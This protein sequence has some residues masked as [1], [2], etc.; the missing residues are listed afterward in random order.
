MLLQRLLARGRADD[1]A[2]VISHRLHVYR[3]QTAPLIA[4]YQELGLLQPVKA[5]G[6]VEEIGE[7]IRALLE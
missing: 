1:N 4:H 7:R 5:S 2:D 3:E 6:S